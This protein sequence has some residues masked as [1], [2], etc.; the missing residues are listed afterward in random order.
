MQ[1]GIYEIVQRTSMKRYVG[2]AVDF[3]ARRRLHISQLKR[4]NHHSLYLQRAWDKYGE[5]EFEFRIILECQKCE[6]ILNEQIEIDKGCD[7]NMS[8]IAGSNLGLKMSRASKN[9]MS[10][11][12]SELS[13]EKVCEIRRRCDNGEQRKAVAEAMGLSKLQVQK[14][15][16]RQ[17]YLWVD[18]DGEP[19]TADFLRSINMNNRG[20]PKI[21][22]KVLELICLDG[23]TFTGTQSEFIA[24]NPDAIQGH[25]SSLFS[26]KRRSHKGW[27]MK[28]APS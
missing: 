16:N 7:Y 1:T 15:A 12:K 4:G 8:M 23:R 24:Q 2:S 13:K 14:I 21:N 9:I 10:I 19:P 28:K 17:S 22:G 3:A 25:V 27:T 6:L 5:S 26:G 20:R 11:K 18:E